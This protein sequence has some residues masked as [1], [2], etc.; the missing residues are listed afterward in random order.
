MRYHRQ[1]LVSEVGL[2]GQLALQKARIL[3]VG[4]GGLG[5][6]AALYLAGAGI[7]TL[8]L[9]DAD[10]VNVSNLH[11]QV[12]YSM[13]D[14]GEKKVRAAKKQMLALNPDII[15]NTHPSDFTA[16][17]AIEIASQYD[18]ILDGSDRFATKFLINDV[19]LKLGIPWIYASVAQWDGQ[20][21]LFNPRNRES[22]CYRC[23]RPEMPKVQIGNCAENGVIGPVVGI[24]GVQEALLALQV[25]L[26]KIKPLTAVLKTFDGFNQEW[27]NLALS[28]NSHCKSCGIP[29][30][31]IKIADEPEFSC[32]L[33]GVT[34]VGTRELK[35]AMPAILAH[36]TLID[37]RET[38]E[39]DEYHI[40]GALHWPLGRLEKNEFPDLSRD[41]TIL[42]YCQAGIRSQ[43]A[44]ELFRN[45]GFQSISDL[46]GGIAA[47]LKL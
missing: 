36:T 45:A 32:D 18:L 7:G 27:M 38:D 14:V 43:K 8:G 21:A 15:V 40:E 19:S 3:I 13:S 44:S 24:L 23:F 46:T 41:R 22:A 5:T 29:A 16:A 30:S 11:R 31:E 12:L 6:P 17:N 1:T 9:M 33:A 4:M 39:W 2:D 35:N 37:V 10:E 25:M 28:K 42:V 20:I 34:K 47:W 26:P